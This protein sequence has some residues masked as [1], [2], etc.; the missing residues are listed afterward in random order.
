MCTLV[1][2]GFTYNFFNYVIN[3]ALLYFADDAY[4]L[5]FFVV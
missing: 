5:E 4:P 2:V 1:F 3:Y